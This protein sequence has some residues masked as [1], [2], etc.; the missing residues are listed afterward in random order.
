MI[1]FL[2]ITYLLN[3]NKQFILHIFY[4]IYL[5]TITNAQDTFLKL[6]QNDEK[7]L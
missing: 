4:L 3:N 5:K 6:I 2:K 1:D 7:L